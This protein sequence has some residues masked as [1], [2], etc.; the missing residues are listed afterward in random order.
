MK[1]M[2]LREQQL[3]SLEILKDVHAFCEK[4]HIKYSL[5]AGT[6]IGAIR[7]NGFIP[8]DDDI[9][10]IM[11]RPDYDVFCRTYKSDAFEIVNYDNDKSFVFIYS[12]VC[13]RT[14]TRYTTYYPCNR[15]GMGIWIDVFPADGFPA[16][17]KLIPE[18]HKK[19]KSL[20]IKKSVFRYGLREKCVF[21]PIKEF[22][23]ILRNI[24]RFV[25]HEGKRTILFLHGWRNPYVQPLI[26]MC[27]TY[28]YGET[29]FWGSVE[30]QGYNMAYYPLE[31]FDSCTLHVF[32]DGEFYIL[33]GWD[34]MLT[35]LYGDYMQL[36][37]EED[38]VPQLASGYKFYWL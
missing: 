20:I 33:K 36:P 6:L 15:K 7:H 32:E 26:D 11:P 22:R 9:D 28:T 38:R 10:I 5:Y 4:N 14:K 35:R 12:R 23:D 21:K 8:W 2:T 34:R 19:A 31:D 1:E 37:P 29:P 24:K 3:F 13:D 17:E 16:D 30:S 18:F 27:H 25:S